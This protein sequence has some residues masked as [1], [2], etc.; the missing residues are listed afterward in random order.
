MRNLDDSYKEISKHFQ[1]ET[2][3]NSTEAHGK[4]TYKK[5]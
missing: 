1:K 4:D 5:H 3:L 2:P